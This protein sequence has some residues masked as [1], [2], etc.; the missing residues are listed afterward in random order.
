MG[1]DKSSISPFVLLRHDESETNIDISLGLLPF[2][3]EAISRGNSHNLGEIT[4][5][6]P[7]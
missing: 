6:L 1:K 5:Q 4:V 7:N 3:L 2:E